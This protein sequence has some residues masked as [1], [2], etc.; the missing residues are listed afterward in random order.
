MNEESSPKTVQAVETTFDIVEVLTDIPAVG[1]SRIADEVGIPVSTAYVHLNTLRERGYV[2][3]SDGAY[4]LSFQFLEH[5][6]AVRQQISFFSDIQD[7]VDQIAYETGE[8]AGFAVEERG[9][10]VVLYRS[11]GTVAAADQIPIGEY[12]HLHWTSM[13]KAIFANLPERRV[14]EI[15]DQHGLPAR[16]SNTITDR[17]E[18]G[19]ELAKV[20][21]CGYAVDNAERRRG[22]RGIA[23]PIIN[24]QDEV[25]GSIGIAG[26]KARLDPSF[27]NRVYDNLL[28]K[29]N[30]IEIR[31][32]F[33]E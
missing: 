26:P 31:N 17:E 14:D 25:I 27:L 24:E 10:R 28:E 20:R 7:A 18:L 3:K 12:T 22:I 16:T 29:R 6:G 5:G 2:V 32:D 4:R 15:V 19:E 8:A 21:A 23:V 33:Y 9:Q 13:G 11:E 30:I 1:V